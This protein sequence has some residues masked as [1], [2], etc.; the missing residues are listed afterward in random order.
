MKHLKAVSLFSGGLDSQLAVC[1]IKNQG[2]E[3]EAVN[4]K[5]PFFGGD[6]MLAEAADKLDITLTTIDISEEYMDLLKNPRYGFGKNMNPCIDC[7]AFM[8]RK[9]GEYMQEADASFIITG[10]VLGQRPMSQNRSSLDAVDKLSGFR[11]FIVR[12]LSAL[13]LK[14][15]IPELEGWLQ[16]ENLLDISGRSRVRQIELAEQVGITEY[17]SP[18]GGCLLTT[19]NYSKRLRQL[20][21]FKPDAGPRDTEVLKYGRHFLLDNRALL[22]VGRKASENEAILNLAEPNDYLIKVATHP[23]PTSLL[24]YFGSPSEEDIKWAAAVTARYSDAIDLPVVKTKV[25]QSDQ[26]LSIVEVKPFTREQS[27]NAL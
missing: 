7:H 19:E 18:A 14:P 8:I 10:E 17:P 13:L 5:S 23:G 6:A 20:L 12:P 24:R 9:A 27:P 16:R 2:V 22:I 26:D 15:T 4:F 25:W 11:G 1:L 3:V 21:N